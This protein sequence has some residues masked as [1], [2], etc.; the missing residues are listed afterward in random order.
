MLYFS[1]IPYRQ[2][3]AVQYRHLSRTVT[4]LCS[5][6]NQIGISEIVKM[7][8]AYSRKCSYYNSGYCKFTRKENGC[9]YLHPTKTC[10]IPK[11]RDKGCPLRDSKRCRHGEECRYQTKCMFNHDHDSTQL[12]SHSKNTDDKKNILKKKSKS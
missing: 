10:K 4:K 3:S 6:R 8:E 11:C 2:C 9:H 7:T 12:R 1:A 5:T